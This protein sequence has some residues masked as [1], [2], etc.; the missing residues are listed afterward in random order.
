[1]DKTEQG[2]QLLKEFETTIKLGK[3]RALSKHSLEHPLTDAQ[4]QQMRTL[5]KDLYGYEMEE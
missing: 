3:L 5:A 4:Y 1:M 2:K